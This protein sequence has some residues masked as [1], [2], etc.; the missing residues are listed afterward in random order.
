[1]ENFHKSYKPEIKVKKPK[2]TVNQKI[3]ELKKLIAGYQDKIRKT[4]GNSDKFREAIDVLE[5]IIRDYQDIKDT[6]MP[7]RFRDQQTD[8]FTKYTVDKE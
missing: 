5:D 8:I 6:G 4:L 2:T 3:R 7:A 1:M